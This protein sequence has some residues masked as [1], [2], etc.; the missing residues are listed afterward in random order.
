MDLEDFDDLDD[1]DEL[2]DRDDLA[3]QDLEDH[4]HLL[5]KEGL[6]LIALGENDIRIAFSSLETK[7]IEGVFEAISRGIKDLS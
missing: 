7:Q 5:E 4:V 1:L 6:G 2:E 3:Q